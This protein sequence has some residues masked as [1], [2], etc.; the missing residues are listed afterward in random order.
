MRGRKP[1]PLTLSKADAP[2]LEFIAQGTT[3]TGRL[4]RIHAGLREN[5]APKLALEAGMLAWPM[6]HARRER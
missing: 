6:L 4:E 5:A 3:L 1:R 2:I